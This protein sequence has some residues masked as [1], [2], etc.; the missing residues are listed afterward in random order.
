MMYVYLNIYLGIGGTVTG[1]TIKKTH[2]DRM[3]IIAL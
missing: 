2:D 3:L 1:G